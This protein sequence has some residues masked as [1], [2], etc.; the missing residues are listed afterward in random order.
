M[1][2]KEACALLNCGRK[3]LN[4]A[5]NRGILRKETV[6]GRAVWNREDVQRLAGFDPETQLTVVYARTAPVRTGDDAVTRLEAQVGRLI[7]FCDSRGWQPDLVIKEVRHVNR[8]E[9]IHGSGNGAAALFGLVAKRRLRRLVIETPDRL[10]VGSSWDLL[11]TLLAF[12]GTELVIVNRVAVTTES[13]AESYAWLQDMAIMHKVLVGEIRDKK[14]E[15]AFFQGQ[16]KA[17]AAHVTE[18]VVRA[19]AKREREARLAERVGHQVSRAPLDL[20]ELFPDP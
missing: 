9:D 5:H 6:R 15:S 8:L 12:Q 13:R 17:T 19:A 16:D 14:I 2:T 3:K 20:D 7:S 4:R 11:R 1:T 18:A 10:M